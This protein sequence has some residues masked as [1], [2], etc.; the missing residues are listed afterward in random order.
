MTGDAHL[1]VGLVAQA[2]AVAAV[3]LSPILACMLAAP[4]L[5]RIRHEHAAM[6]G[7]K[8]RPVASRPQPVKRLRKL[9]RQLRSF[10]TS[11]RSGQNRVR[12]ERVGSGHA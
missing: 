6:M 4:R 5:H 9:V 10:L 1:T 12:H 11:A 2:L 7:K 8:P 3:V